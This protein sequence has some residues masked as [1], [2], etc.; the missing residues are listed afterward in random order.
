MPLKLK[1]TK[2]FKN[3]SDAERKKRRREWVL[4]VLIIF[5]IAALTYAQTRGI[6]FGKSIPVSST[7]LMFIIININLLL[8]IILFFL[9]VRNV[10]KLL[11]ERRSRV[12][13]SQLRTKLALSF[14]TLS[15]VPTAVLFFFSLLFISH[16]ITS[17]FNVPVLNS[18]ESSLEVG[19]ELYEQVE[20]N[21]EFF[22]QRVA[23]QVK[24]KNYL[25]PDRNKALSHYVVIT[26]REFNLDAV[27]IYGPDAALTA[28]SSDLFTD[29]GALPPLKLADLQ[30]EG[31]SEEKKFYTFNVSLPHGE[32]VRTIGP[33]PFS[34]T[35]KKAAG[36]VAIS[37]L[38]PAKLSKNLTSI[39]DGVDSYRQTQ[40]LKDP[41]ESHLY[42]TLSIVAMLV[43]FCA[44]W[45]GFHLAKTLTVPIAHLAEGTRRVAGGDLEFTLLKIADDE[46]GSLVDAFNKM[47]R[48]LR[49]SREQLEYT[50]L[51][52]AEQNTEIENRRVY[53][54]V[55]LRNVSAG[56]ISLDDSGR[57]ATINTSAEKMLGIR[58][59]DILGRSYKDM[60][61]GEYTL[62]VEEALEKLEMSGENYLEIPV[63][64]IVNERPRSFL[65][66]VSA[67]VDD[68][69]QDM[70]MVVVFDD[71]TELE[72]AQRLAAW[73][74]VARRV[75]HEVKNPLTPIKLS[76]QRLARK[77]QDQVDDPVFGKCTDTIIE[78][79][80]VIRNLVNEF[81]AYA[82][83]PSPAPTPCDLPALTAEAMVPYLES[84]GEIRFE[85]SADENT[86]RLMLDHRQIKRALINLVD[87]AIAAIE[88]PGAIHVSVKYNPGAKTVRV[89]VADTGKGITAE[90]KVRLFE[91]Y[92]S[93]K[94][95]G[96]GLGLSIVNT[97][98]T[99][100]GGAIR[101]ANN[102][103]KGARFIVEFP[104][105]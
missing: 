55:V 101:V 51:R 10:V 74:E 4:A 56:V 26:Q 54:E 90:E 62:V 77:F 96:T 7:V 37:T 65:V 63:K 95:A 92:F 16:S 67:L 1:N 66:H 91:P 11:Y 34:E 40:I 35:R 18:L 64:L 25:D 73:R 103:P 43:L 15:I 97:I 78:Q 30:K 50:A 28:F 53:M 104:V 94:K 83:F 58:G 8:V 41:F 89:E 31:D 72:R 19:R 9:V 33:I 42:I 49:M 81:S 44:I 87:N 70:G 102:H 20:S 14:I 61:S 45:F 88:G 82:R 69:N 99:D 59:E 71:L 75:A 21:H 80:D 12:L 17:W 13:G 52:L 23:Y 46:M 93:T 22:V 5:F 2:G 3:I 76:A 85:L 38:L 48:D 100:H 105:E 27:E 98:V 32:L 6:Q 47:T 29:S 79:V 68:Q 86:P 24:A 57:F 60:L 39:K 36:F 84:P